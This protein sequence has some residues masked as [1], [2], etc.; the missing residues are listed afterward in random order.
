[1]A[2][3]A[4]SRVAVPATSAAAKCSW[5]LG[6]LGPL[7]SMGPLL[8]G[9]SGSRLVCELWALLEGRSPAGRSSATLS[10]Y[11]DTVWK[12]EYVSTFPDYS[13]KTR[14]NLYRLVM[15]GIQIWYHN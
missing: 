10:H 12:K 11:Y 14:L 8:Y 4:N 3:Q 1:M 15:V 13:D 9:G 5:L 2:V 6:P 7:L